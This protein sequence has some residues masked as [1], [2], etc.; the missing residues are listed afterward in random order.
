MTHFKISLSLVRVSVSFGK[1]N[2]V[3]RS[4]QNTPSAR[5]NVKLCPRARVARAHVR[6]IACVASWWRVTIHLKKKKKNIHT[7]FKETPTNYIAIEWL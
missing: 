1:Q 6:P 3:I 2:C 4:Y 7:I 5:D